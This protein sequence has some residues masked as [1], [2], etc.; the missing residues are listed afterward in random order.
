L[1]HTRHQQKHFENLEK[2]ANDWLKRNEDKQIEP[3]QVAELFTI[4]TEWIKANATP[5]GG[6]KAAQVK[7]IGIQYP[8]PNKW[9][10]ERHGKQITQESRKAFESFH[11]GYMATSKSKRIMHHQENAQV[12]VERPV[13]KQKRIIEGEIYA[14]TGGRI[15]PIC[16][17]NAL[18]WEDCKHTD[19]QA[20]TEMRRQLSGTHPH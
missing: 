14:T 10:R 6:Y 5:A 13:N 4:T 12:V 16:T 11:A 1:K 2:Q 18:P 7:F 9:M 20:N 19:Q 17:C 8:L 3:V 15:K